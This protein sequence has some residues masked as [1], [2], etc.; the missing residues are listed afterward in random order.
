MTES[1]KSR[2]EEQ[3]PLHECPKC[4]LEH[5]RIPHIQQG[6]AVWLPI[7]LIAVAEGTINPGRIGLTHMDTPAHLVGMLWGFPRSP[8]P[9]LRT[10]ILLN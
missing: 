4:K 3:Y 2:W 5:T 8:K 9:L 10:L 1:L 7:E 6:E